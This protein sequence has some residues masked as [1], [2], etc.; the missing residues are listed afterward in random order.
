M[1]GFHPGC[2]AAGLMV[3]A[4]AMLSAPPAMA[5][6]TLDKQAE[7]LVKVLADFLEKNAGKFRVARFIEQ[8]PIARN[9]DKAILAAILRAVK[10]AN[11]DNRLAE[12]NLSFILDGK[13]YFN[14]ENVCYEIH[15]ELTD[16][17]TRRSTDAFNSKIFPVNSPADVIAQVAPPALGNIFTD[18]AQ[19]NQNLS[20]I[21][22]PLNPARPRPEAD[23]N[24]LQNL[25]ESGDL[26]FRNEPKSPY[27][28]QILAGPD[29]RNVKPR[30]FQVKDGAVWVDMKAEEVYKVTFANDSKSV[31]GVNL[32]L[33]GLNRYYFASPSNRDKDGDPKYFYE[34]VKGNGSFT[35]PGWYTDDS[36]VRD[37]KLQEVPAGGDIS[38]AIGP[39]NRASIGL[40][41]IHVHASQRSGDLVVKEDAKPKR[42]IFTGQGEASNEK[43]EASSLR[44]NGDM[45]GSFSVRYSLPVTDNP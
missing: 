42:A 13:I 11:L 31:V 21:L 30:R 25:L 7:N 45:V 15:P 9:H 38:K 35:I 33:D 39:R 40:I 29:S 36:T 26:W 2:L 43:T 16:L 27:R 34:V 44:F 12:E 10:K 22:A 6:E 24:R 28:I 20:N 8:G 17:K 4:A 14:D 18:R 3:I 1:T 37:F 5:D 32:V 41:S 23:N 19:L